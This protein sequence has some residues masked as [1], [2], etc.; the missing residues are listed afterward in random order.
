MELCAECKISIYEKITD[1]F[2]LMRYNACNKL[3]AGDG[4]ANF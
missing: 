1:Y 4:K 2:V 3:Y